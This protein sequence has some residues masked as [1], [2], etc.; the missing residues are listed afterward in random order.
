MLEI[1]YFFISFWFRL[2]SDFHCQ[3]FRFGVDGD[4]DDDDNNDDDDDDN[5]SDVSL[6]I[7]TQPGAFLILQFRDL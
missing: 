2:N 3:Y 6:T 5:V 4:D 1:I 7:P